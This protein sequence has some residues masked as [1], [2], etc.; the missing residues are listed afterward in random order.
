MEFKLY[1]LTNTSVQLL[2]SYQNSWQQQKKLFYLTFSQSYNFFTIL[3]HASPASSC[4]L[5]DSIWLHSCMHLL[6]PPLP[7]HK[8][9]YLNICTCGILKQFKYIYIWHIA[10]RVVHI[11]CT[12]KHKTT[13]SCSKQIIILQFI[14]IIICLYF[15]IAIL[16]LEK[17]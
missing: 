3:V 10:H 17:I 15:F 13:S 12:I 9:L 8:T 16:A 2:K 4:S 5:H 11:I 1:F 7:P 14:A 6:P